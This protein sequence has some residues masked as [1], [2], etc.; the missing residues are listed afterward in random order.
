VKDLSEIFLESFAAFDAGCRAKMWDLNKQKIDL[1]DGSLSQL[2][3]P[4]AKRA[5]YDQQSIWAFISVWGQLSWFY[6]LAWW[7]RTPEHQE[8]A[9]MKSIAGDLFCYLL[10]LTGDIEKARWLMAGKDQGLRPSDDLA[11]L[12]AG[13]S[14]AQ[15]EKE[16]RRVFEWIESGH[17]V[18]TFM[19]YSEYKPT[20]DPKNDWALISTSVITARR[21]IDD[22]VVRPEIVRWVHNQS[23][24]NLSDGGI[25][26]FPEMHPA[27]AKA[28][29]HDLKPTDPWIEM[30]LIRLWPFF[31]L[32]KWTAAEILES[33]LRPNFPN[34]AAAFDGMNQKLR[35]LGLRN[36]VGA[37][38]GEKGGARDNPPGAQY[39]NLFDVK[40]NFPGFNPLFY[41]LLKPRP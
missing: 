29:Q 40:G 19:L 31:R 37:G 34:Q 10:E 38:E 39:L 21:A 9:A 36:A 18:G 23:Y 32:H 3:F 28:K 12:H 25:A 5:G 6:E 11:A 26:S 14:D 13:K 27:D 30:W 15:Y 1:L 22:N 7:Q 4:A 17:A 20:S 33:W 8:T 24:K 16:N 41:Y 35:R 2:F